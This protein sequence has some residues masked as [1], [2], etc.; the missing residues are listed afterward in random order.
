[1]RRGAGGRRKGYSCSMRWVEIRVERERGQLMSGT[2][3]FAPGR[4]GRVTETAPPGER[5]DSWQVAGL[6]MISVFGASRSRG[7]CSKQSDLSVGHP[8]YRASKCLHDYCLPT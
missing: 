7:G 5:R 2:V 4:S 8:L 1:M 6:R 3:E